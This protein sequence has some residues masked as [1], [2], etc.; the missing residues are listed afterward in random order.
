MDLK[1]DL[2]LISLIMAVITGTIGSGW[3]F[4]PYYVA[5]TAG[6][7]SL[8]AWLLGGF[9]AFL[10]AL[11]FAEL[12]SLIKSS[13]ALAQIPMLSHGRLSGFIGGWSIWISYLCMPTIELLAMFEYLASRFPWLT[14]DKGSQQI[15]SVPGLMI[16]GSLMLLFTW[17]NLNGIKG[18]ARWVNNLTIWKL[19]VPVFVATILILFSGHWGNLNVQ[20][21]S[22]QQQGGDLVRAVGSGGIL[23]S[24]LGFRTAVDLAGETRNPQR[25]VPLAI[26]LGLV[27][28]LLI[29]M[30]LQLSFLVSVPPV[31]LNN[32]WAALDLSQHGGPLAALALDLGLGWIVIILLI[33]AAISP[34]TTALAYLGVSARV[35][36]MMG[37]CRLLPAALARTNRHGI[38]DIAVLSSTVVGICLFLVGPAWQQIVSFLTAAQMIALAMGPPSLLAL[39]RQLP[40]KRKHFQMPLARTICALAF[41]MATWASHWCGRTA[42]EGAILA[43]GIPSLIYSLYHWRAQ[44][45]ID[46]TSGLWWALYLGLM[47]LDMEL[48]SPGMRLAL[49]TS[50]NLFILAGIALLI[51]PVAVNSALKEVSPYALTNL[52]NDQPILDS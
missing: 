35:S 30:I 23:F 51:L 29:Y 34:S 47:V 42:L 11:V 13:G 50:Q 16:A 3:L 21:H 46:A 24:L 10:L 48:F 18:L 17:V 45:A 1:R 14:Q 27:I 31:E 7:S 39:R 52:A 9:I 26:G 43:I 2:G 44:E 33:D 25:N 38:P 28:S 22:S 41:V 6:P 8:L 20:V 49:S 36:W 15:L 40:G 4:A 12:G 32:G 5:R 37:Q 19:I